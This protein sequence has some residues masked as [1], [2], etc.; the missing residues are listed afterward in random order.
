MEAFKKFK[1]FS[2]GC[3]INSPSMAAVNRHR[4]GARFPSTMIND[5]LEEGDG[6]FTTYCHDP[7]EDD[8]ASIIDKLELLK[9]SVSFDAYKNCNE[10]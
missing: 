3:E 6:D 10:E 2:R 5:N 1:G 7:M 9:Q 8:S 4:K